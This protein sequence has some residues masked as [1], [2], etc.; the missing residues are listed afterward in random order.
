MRKITKEYQEDI[1]IFFNIAYF[2]ISENQISLQSDTSWSVQ[3]VVKSGLI[4]HTGTSYTLYSNVQ[5]FEKF[6]QAWN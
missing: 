1:Y 4:F 6:E 2:S 5:R 3:E